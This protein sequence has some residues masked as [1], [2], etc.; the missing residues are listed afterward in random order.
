MSHAHAP[1]ACTLSVDTKVK[2]NLLPGG[3]KVFTKE[4]LNLPMPTTTS[5][6]PQVM[7][8]PELLNTKL[9]RGWMKD[10]SDVAQLMKANSL[11]REYSVDGAVRMD[12]EKAWDI[13]TAEMAREAKARLRMEQ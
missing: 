7:T 4:K 3:G 9:S 1:E 8:L 6:Q 12:Y 5:E 2:I 13:A 10:L 11:P